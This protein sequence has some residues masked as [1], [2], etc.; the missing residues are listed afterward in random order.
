GRLLRRWFLEGNVPVKLGSLVLFAGVA[1]ALKYASD[2]GYF[3]LPI[4]LRLPGI[5]LA[6]I[7]ALLWGWRNR[8]ARPAFGLSL[9][10][11]AVGVLLLTV[12]AA[13]RI[14]ALLPA[15]LAL[16][17]VVG[18]VAATALLAVLQDALWLAL[19]GLV[20]GYLAP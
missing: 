1:A 18:L 10:G 6:A 8:H 16:A 17:L 12:F 5:A 2:Q 11:M 15:G 4:E 13:F 19:L 7:G 14:Y 20:G 3:T 9:Q